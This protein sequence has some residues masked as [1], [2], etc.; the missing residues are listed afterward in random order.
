MYIYIYIK[1]VYS[2]HLVE[3]GN[4]CKAKLKH[5]PF[6]YPHP[7]VKKPQNIQVNTM[8]NK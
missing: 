5:P 6:F 8:A 4:I 3:F 7:P 1:S 2:K